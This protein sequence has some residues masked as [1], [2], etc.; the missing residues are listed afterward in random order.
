MQ[1]ITSTIK[2]GMLVSLK[3]TISG[4][5]VSY[6]RRVIEAE[7]VTADGKLQASWETDKLVLDAAE[8]DLAKKARADA[9]NAI[10]AACV[11]SDFGLLCPMENEEKLNAAIAKATDIIAAFNKQA[12]FSKISVYALTGKIEVNDVQAVAGINSEIRDLLMDMESGVTNGDVR[13]IREAA[14]KARGFMPML[15]AEPAAFLESAI[16]MVRDVARA[17][18]KDGSAPEVLRAESVMAINDAMGTFS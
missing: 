16:E 3:T 18:V 7:H 17:I 1:V 5:N 11:H 8:H 9:R 2:P 15:V 6:H 14:N 12:K 13:L 10:S 4:L